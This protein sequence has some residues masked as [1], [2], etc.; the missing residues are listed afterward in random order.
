[1]SLLLFNP[2]TH[3]KLNVGLGLNPI[4]SVKNEISFDEDF[5]KMR[6]WKPDPVHSSRVLTY[7]KEQEPG[8]KVLPIILSSRLSTNP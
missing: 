6:L 5:G 3:E 7:H 8:M 1:M 2:A 4:V